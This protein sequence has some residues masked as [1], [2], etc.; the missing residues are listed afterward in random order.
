[1]RVANFI[2]PRHSNSA[3]A[4]YAS[5]CKIPE[6]D[7]AMMIQSIAISW[8]NAQNFNSGLYGAVAMDRKGTVQI[9]FLYTSTPAAT[10]TFFEEPYIATMT[11]SAG[12][13]SGGTLE[14]HSMPLYGCQQRA[15][16]IQTVDHGNGAFTLEGQVTYSFACADDDNNGVSLGGYANTAPNRP[17]YHA[18]S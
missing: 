7:P 18:R 16:S 10:G 3:T 2:R 6:L 5:Y 11:I 9:G 8:D 13:Y 17:W 14:N 15:I 4:D 1:M 12:F